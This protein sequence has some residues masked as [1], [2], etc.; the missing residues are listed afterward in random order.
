LHQAESRLAPGGALLLE[1]EA[2]QG[3]S[4]PRAARKVFPHARVDVLPDLAGH[5]RL[6][7]VLV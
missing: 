1:I 2:T 4:A 5:P 7:Q 6:L 3:E